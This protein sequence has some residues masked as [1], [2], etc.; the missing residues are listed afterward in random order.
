[1]MAPTEILA[2]QHFRLAKKIFEH[3]NI[4]IELLTGKTKSNEKK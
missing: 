2:N 1:M 4:S 3:T